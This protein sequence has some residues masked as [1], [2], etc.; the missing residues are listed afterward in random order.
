MLRSTTMSDDN[1]DQET[2]PL[3][4]RNSIKEEHLG[5]LEVGN[6]PDFPKKSAVPVV[7]DD[8]SP[9][10]SSTTNQARHSASSSLL[11]RLESSGDVPNGYLADGLS[12]P[13]SEWASPNKRRCQ[14][15]K[16]RRE[17]S[18]TSPNR[19]I[20]RTITESPIP[21]TRFHANDT[22]FHSA[23]T[24][25]PGDLGRSGEPSQS[26]HRGNSSNQGLTE[27]SPKPNASLTRSAMASVSA[28]PESRE[29]LSHGQKIVGGHSAVAG[30][31]E[32][33]GI[34][35]QPETHPITEDQLANEV[36]GIYAGL[37]MVEKKCIDIVKQQ[38]VQESELSHQQWQAL[39]ALHRT[40]LQ[41]HH[42]FFMASQHPSA[43]L[44]LRK[45]SEKY[46]VPARMWRYGIQTFLELLH[47]RLPDSL[48]HMLTFIYLAYSMLTLLLETVPAFEETWIECLGDLSRYGVVIEERGLLD[49]E[50]WVGIARYWYNKA[51][52]KNPDVGR[53]Q[54][55]L[56]VLAR[57]DIVQQLF[58]YTKSLVSVRPFPRTRV[59]ILRFFSPLLQGPRGTSYPHVTT[60]FVSAHGY[61]FTQATAVHFIQSADEFLSSLDKH[62]PRVGV[63]FRVQGVYLAS[64]NIAAMLEYSNT[65]AL[66]CAEFHQVAAQQ[67]QPCE[68]LSPEE[69]DPIAD[70]HEAMADFLALGAQKGSSQLAYGSCLAFETFSVLL[71]YIGNMNLF[72]AL[73]VSLAFL[74]CLSSSATSMKSVEAVVPWSRIVI[75]LNTIIQQS[76]LQ[77]MVQGW[78]ITLD[79]MDFNL[80]EGA[81][82]PFSDETRWIPEDFLIRGQIWSQNY[83]PRSFFEKCPTDEDGRNVERESLSISRI[84]RCLWL[85]VRLAKFNRWIVY[86][87][88]S[89]EFTATPFAR[90]LETALKLETVSELE[91]TVE[92]K[93]DSALYLLRHRF[94]LPGLQDGVPCPPS[95]D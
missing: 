4:I 49:H 25:S 39:I 60:A 29:G 75:F 51:V 74:W 50:I 23:S 40:L 83:Y 45:S 92:T 86:D 20:S 95:V 41:E 46:N 1:I 64:S 79:D 77:R 48:E 59:S 54:H 47:R 61:L 27:S 16:D 87:S 65:D 88:V 35:L 17:P 43:N 15:R 57:P 69:R 55:H 21:T 6:E 90:E 13:G 5:S 31:I 78:S 42:D 70:A 84:Y 3:R 18:S 26:H 68:A 94:R 32:S 28:P 72:P 9:A 11:K 24:Y 81:E 52:D 63:S 73:H 30:G 58:Y 89:R 36:R 76:F 67:S 7:S 33:T 93:P 8:G 34:T 22:H 12:D 85:G 37:V 14:S 2:F 66:L 91:K 71:E 80:I 82:F 38:F 10:G 62:I 53:I 19:P 56:G 44:A